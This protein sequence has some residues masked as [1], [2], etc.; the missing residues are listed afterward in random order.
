[1]TKS[2]KSTA[3]ALALVA[4]LGLGASTAAQAGG[5]DDDNVFWS[6]AMSQPGVRVAVSNMPAAPVVVHERRHIHVHPQPVYVPPPRVVYMPPAYHHHP[7][8]GHAYGHWRDRDHDRHGHRG[9]YR[10]DDRREHRGGDR[11]AYGHGRPAPHLGR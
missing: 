6:I 3:A 11:H 1:M 2:S 8:R 7:G 9:E 4:A 5:Y 10:G